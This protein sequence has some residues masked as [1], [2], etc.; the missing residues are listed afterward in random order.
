MPFERLLEDISNAHGPTTFTA[1]M[2]GKT[3]HHRN[4]TSDQRG[5]YYAIY[6]HAS[7]G[8]KTGEK[9]PN[10]MG[11]YVWRA[12]LDVNGDD[13][14]PLAI[15]FDL[16]CYLSPIRTP[17]KD[18]EK[19]AAIKDRDGV[20]TLIQVTSK[21]L[22]L[23]FPIEN[24]PDAENILRKIY[25]KYVLP[26]R[27]PTGGNP[28]RAFLT[29]PVP[30]V[31]EGP[32]PPGVRR[33]DRRANTTPPRAVPVP[34]PEPAGKGKTWDYFSKRAEVAKP[35]AESQPEV[36][37]NAMVDLRKVGLKRRLKEQED[38]LK[39]VL[40]EYEVKLRAL[41]N[42]RL[43]LQTKQDEV[44][45]LQNA[46]ATINTDQDDLTLGLLKEVLESRYEKIWRHGDYY[47]ALTRP[48]V[49]QYAP[50]TNGSQ[51]PCK[52]MAGKF[53]I[54]VD[55]AGLVAFYREDGR[56]VNEPSEDVTGTRGGRGWSISPHN[57]V[58]WGDGSGICWGTQSTAMTAAQ[59]AAD[60]SQIFLLTYQHLSYVNPDESYVSLR[61]YAKYLDLPMIEDPAILDFQAYLEDQKEQLRL[62]AEKKEKEAADLLLREQQAL[63]AAEKAANARAAN[64]QELGEL[65]MEELAA[66]GLNPR[67]LRPGNAPVGVDHTHDEINPDYLLEGH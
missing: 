14:Q 21:A 59:E 43:A 57:T 38:A 31:T 52:V 37:I 42:Q 47:W 61:G 20:N 28:I 49:M 7:Y 60:F 15:Q 19:Y 9:P 41:Q 6:S 66:Y 35:P 54:R 17:P 39:T 53:I 1:D 67:T 50:H 44:V 26:I 55:Q 13:G 56:Q 32:P 40:R 3:V 2:E 65:T 23:L 63:E 5:Y 30:E 62:E 25:E 22:Y 16:G 8:S 64:I 27:L 18:G 51:D 45:A 36:V 58:S 33:R 10:K 12:Q 4:G 24:V 34:P 46:M 11:P 48:I 29:G